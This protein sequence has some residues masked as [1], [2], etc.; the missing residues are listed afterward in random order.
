MKIKILWNEYW[1]KCNILLQVLCELQVAL[2]ERAVTQRPDVTR[3]VM[4]SEYRNMAAETYR[5]LRDWLIFRDYMNGLEFIVQV[6]EHLRRILES[7]GR[8]GGSKRRVTRRRLARLR[9]T[10]Q[11]RLEALFSW[12]ADP[13]ALL[14]DSWSRTWFKIWGIIRFF[15]CWT[16][17]RSLE[18]YFSIEIGFF[19]RHW[20]MENPWRR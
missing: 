17:L 15:S 11:L 19:W 12:S 4:S 16:S 6:F 8:L 1:W 18:F 2:V 10:A 7:W 5:N 9:K 13:K 3:E 20:K 14:S